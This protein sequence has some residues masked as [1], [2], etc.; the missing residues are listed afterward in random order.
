M[1]R[2]AFKPEISY[3]YSGNNIAALEEVFN[4]IFESCTNDL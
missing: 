3:R 1:S 2:P 4:F